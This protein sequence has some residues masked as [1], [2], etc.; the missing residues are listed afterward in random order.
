[1]DW[2][3][4]A[5]SFA[6]LVIV[7]SVLLGGFGLGDFFSDII[8]T[9]GNF[10]TASPFGGIAESS[11]ASGIAVTLVFYPDEFVLSTEHGVNASING[12]S[13]EMF[14]GEIFVDYEDGS[15]VMNPKETGMSIKT[16]LQE[17]LLEGIRLSELSV[18]DTGFEITENETGKTTGTGTIRIYGFEGNFTVRTEGIEFDGR[19]S[20]VS[21]T[22]G[23]SHW[24]L[25]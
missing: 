7:S 24:E 19:V 18:E 22:S 25:S 8:N 17:F 20:S 21:M 4:M 15:I 10:L 3:I 16:E 13:M 14:D 23:E 1:M 5:A 12:I 9:I 11:P 2:K 6:A